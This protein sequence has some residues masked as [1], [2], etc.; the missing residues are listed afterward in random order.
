MS[1]VVQ[2]L[3]R[4]QKQVMALSTALQ[5][6]RN[7][8]FTLLG[9][10]WEERATKVQNELQS[11]GVSPRRETVDNGEIQPLAPCSKIASC[12]T[13]LLDTASCGQSGW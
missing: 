9:S 12:T 8:P 2:W 3:R 5:I 13:L 10:T 6:V 1:R 4:D 7:P 11:L